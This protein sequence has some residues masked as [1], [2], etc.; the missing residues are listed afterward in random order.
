[1][2]RQK[3]VNLELGGNSRKENAKLREAIRKARLKPY[4]SIPDGMDI[5]HFK[6]IFFIWFLPHLF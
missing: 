5:Q 1:M 6:E 3:D 2:I 4:S